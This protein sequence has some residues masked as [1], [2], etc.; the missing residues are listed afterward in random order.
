MFDTLRHRRLIL[1]TLTLALILGALILSRLSRVTPH[2]RDAATAGLEDR[3]RSDIDIESLQV[4]IFPRP[5]VVGTGLSVRLKGTPKITPMIR[6]DAYAANGG[7]WGLTST[8]V[9]LKKVDLEGLAVTLQPGPRRA[10]G[11]ERENDRPKP[12]EPSTSASKSR[13]VID[14]IV[15][16]KATLE[17]LSRDEGKLPRVFEI[18]DRK[19]VV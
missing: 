9:R 19:S 4:S 13:L 11:A 17:I 16:R 10:P 2:V 12:L 6:V 14:E 3:F 15:A 18:Q 8:P 1:A 7:L 5:E